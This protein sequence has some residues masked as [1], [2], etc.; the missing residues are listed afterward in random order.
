[1]N[2]KI[3]LHHRTK[4][5]FNSY[6]M[7]LP[8][9]G[10]GGGRLGT[11]LK[12]VLCWNPSWIIEGCPERTRHVHIF[13]SFPRTFCTSN[14]RLSLHSSSPSIPGFPSNPRSSQVHPGMA[15]SSSPSIPGFPSNRKGHPGMAYSA[16]PGWLLGNHGILWIRSQV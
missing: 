7:S 8:S 2:F 10:G 3:T 15:Y 9:R 11:R 4:E 12:P 6:Q 14:G 16:P 5:C 13:L 1:M